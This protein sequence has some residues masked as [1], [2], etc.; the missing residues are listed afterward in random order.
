MRYVAALVVLFLTLGASALDVS[1]RYR[2]PRN[3]ERRV[4]ASTELIVLHTRKARFIFDKPVPWT[5]DG[6]AGGEHQDIILRNYEAPLR[7]IF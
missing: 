6:E 5:R 3:A 1:N 7:F 4:R 2:S